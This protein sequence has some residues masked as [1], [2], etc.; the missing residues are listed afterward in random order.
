MSRGYGER[1]T[2]SYCSLSAESAGDEEAQERE[3]SDGCIVK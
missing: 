3:D 2:E 1:A